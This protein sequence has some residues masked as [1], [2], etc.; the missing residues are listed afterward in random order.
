MVER[1]IFSPKSVSESPFVSRG[2]LKCLYTEQATELTQKLEE[3]GV[4]KQT[5]VD[6]ANVSSIKSGLGISL[7]RDE[8]E[9]SVIY[10]QNINQ[11]ASK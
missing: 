6:L 3:I 9:R 5:I 1:Q 11:D 2:V 10:W 7:F 4:N 8:G